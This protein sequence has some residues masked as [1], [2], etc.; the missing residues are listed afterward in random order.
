MIEVLKKTSEKTVLKKTDRPNKVTDGIITSYFCYKADPD[1]Y[2]LPS[3][4][5]NKVDFYINS[6]KNSHNYFKIDGEIKVFERTV[7]YKKKNEKMYV[8]EKNG[9]IY[10]WNTIYFEFFASDPE[11]DFYICENP[12]I[13]TLIQKNGV[14]T[15]VLMPIGN[16]SLTVDE[17]QKL[18]T[19]S[20]VKQS[21]KE[22][23]EVEKAEKAAAG[24]EKISVFES[25]NKNKIVKRCYYAKKLCENLYII[26]DFS[27]YTT[28]YTKIILYFPGYTGI[29]FG[30]RYGGI[31]EP[32][33]ISNFKKCG[34]NTLESF[35]QFFTAKKDAG[36]KLPL[37][38][39]FMLEF[40]KQ[41]KQKQKAAA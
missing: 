41:K 4:I 26:E 15:G 14:F 10:G 22:A 37:T 7:K 3:N 40:I 29:L 23:R 32:E 6:F 36:V 30:S 16:V 34:F 18:P 20:K 39:E 31:I 8:Y 13:G 35:I 9:K 25:D 21:K 2:D 11:N 38:V 5:N 24:L 33:L 12:N 27:K 28:K 19:V 1:K 17:Y